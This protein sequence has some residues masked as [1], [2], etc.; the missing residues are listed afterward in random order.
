MSNERKAPRVE[1]TQTASAQAVAA[2]QAPVTAT[3]SQGRVITLKRPGVLAQYR[4]VEILGETASNDTYMRMVLPLI[5]VTSIDG[6]A[7]SFPTTKRQIE[8][9]IQ[10][11]DDHGIEAVM[12]SVREN[13]GQ[14]DPEADKDSLKK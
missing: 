6:E 4:L 2:A 13:F 9:L 12:N 8:A 7:V 1:L 10:R 5:Y 3:D 14:R 11:L